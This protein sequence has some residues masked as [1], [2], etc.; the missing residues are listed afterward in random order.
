MAD[1]VYAIATERYGV[2]RIVEDSIA[3]ARVRARAMF[4]V[5]PRSVH[6][7]TYQEPCPVCDSKPCCCGRPA[8]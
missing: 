8:M 6:R 7:E 5:G 3:A 1:H 4:G 2:V